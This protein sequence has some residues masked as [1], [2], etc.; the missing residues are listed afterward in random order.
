MLR[1]HCALWF[2]NSLSNLWWCITAAAETQLAV[3]LL[4]PLKKK[5]TPEN[6]QRKDQSWQSIIL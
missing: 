5:K 3:T 6:S 1:Q 2:F 4:I